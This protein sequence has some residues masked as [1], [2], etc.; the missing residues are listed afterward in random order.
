MG[1][2][3]ACHGVAGG[4]DE[5]F[6]GCSGSRRTVADGARRTKYRARMTRRRLR[7]SGARRGAVDRHTSACIMA[8]A[9]LPRDDA[10]GRGAA[11]DRGAR[12]HTGRTPARAAPAP[13]TVRGPVA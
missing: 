8:V 12:A 11:C 9:P 1:R 2:A 10:R 13:A 3:G 7:A 4:V 6:D 5:G